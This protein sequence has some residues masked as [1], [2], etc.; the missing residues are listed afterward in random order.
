MS[1]YTPEQIARIRA[2]SERLLSDEPPPPPEPTPPRV[3]RIEVEDDLVRWRREADESDRERE[4]ARAELRR[5]SREDRRAAMRTR[6]D[7]AEVDQRL[8]AIED[9]L[10][11]IEQALAAFNQLASN[12]ATFSDSVT[13]QLESLAALANRV[14]AATVTLRYVHERETAALRDRLAASEATHARETA[15]LTRELTRAQHET[16][17]RAEIRE[18]A[19]NRMAVAGVDAK[20][21]NVVQLVH[22]D[23]AARKR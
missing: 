8:D 5:E 9:R 4:A 2:E 13:G 11:A 10:T 7:A 19:A 18:H 1:R 12:T 20:L 3:V 17:R 22:E 6:Q 21:E 15:L 23:L 16:D 14:D